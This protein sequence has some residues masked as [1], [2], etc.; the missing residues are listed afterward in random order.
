M[1]IVFYFHVFKSF[2]LIIVITNC[3]V[4]LGEEKWSVWQDESG[5][6][7]KTRGGNLTLFLVHF[8]FNFV[9]CGLLGKIYQAM[10]EYGYLLFVYT[11]KKS[12]WRFTAENMHHHI[13]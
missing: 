6:M 11:S 2:L 4:C 7:Q 13:L 5:G 10:E 8:K 9:V 3:V 1:L 12:H